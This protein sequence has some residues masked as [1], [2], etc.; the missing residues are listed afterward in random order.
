MGVVWQALL[1]DLAT[2]RGDLVAVGDEAFG[3]RLLALDR[4]RG[5]V[6]VE[7]GGQTY[8]LRLGDVDRE[9]RATGTD[10]S[11]SPGQTSQRPLPSAAAQSADRPQSGG[12]T[13]AER[14]QKLMQRFGGD[15]PPEMIE[16]YRE[17]EQR[18]YGY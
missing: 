15:L 9:D 8:V 12:L 14:L 18:R 16:R 13:S 10:P 7:R 11:S 3:Y 2:E 5:R 6:T 4:Q 17:W 1:E